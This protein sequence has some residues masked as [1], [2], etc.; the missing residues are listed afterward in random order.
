MASIH[1]QEQLPKTWFGKD[2]SLEP[3]NKSYIFPW[4]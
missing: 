4:K 2:N 3:L 1:S